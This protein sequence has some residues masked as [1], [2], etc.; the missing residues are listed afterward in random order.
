[1]SFDTSECSKEAIRRIIRAVRRGGPAWERAAPQGDA[2]LCVMAWFM[3]DRCPRLAP[4]GFKRIYGLLYARRVEGGELWNGV[5]IFKELVH[6]E[7]RRQELLADGW[8]I[9]IAT[10]EA[11]PPLEEIVR[12]R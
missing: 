9:Y 3:G 6:A 10:W 1:M 11:R 8:T 5:S 12:V 4:E 2:Q 7:A